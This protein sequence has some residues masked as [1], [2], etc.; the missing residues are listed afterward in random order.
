M[1][2]KRISIISFAIWMVI[3]SSA[4]GTIEFH[5]NINSLFAVPPN[6]SAR[7]GFGDF[8]LEPDGLFTG[9][10]G[11]V[12]WSDVSTVS[13]FRA[14]G[15]QD[16]GSRLFDFTPGLIVLP[17]PSGEF[18]GGDLGGRQYDLSR[19]LI[20]TEI[21][22][23]NNGLWWVSVATPGFPNGEIRGQIVAVPEPAAF[24][25]IPLGII[26]IWAVTKQRTR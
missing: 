25:L 1:N 8:T 26:G 22:D 15:P 16:I 12:D 20:S 4:Q 7:T 18:G 19:T 5:A 13:I 10:V 3:S 9:V 14:N 21:A 17:Y 6:A 23:L 2:T 11:I 24:L